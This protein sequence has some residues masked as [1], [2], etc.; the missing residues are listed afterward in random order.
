MSV[1]DSTL[2][3]R[4]KS[5]SRTVYSRV[6]FY[7]ND[8]TM[9][10]SL[11]SSTALISTVVTQPYASNGLTL[12]E[13]C[14]SQ[15]D[16][17][18]YNPEQFG[19]DSQRLLYKGAEFDVYMGFAEGDSIP[20]LNNIVGSAI[21][22]QAIIGGED[23]AEPIFVGRF[24]AEEPSTNDDW[25]TIS[26]RGYDTLSR[27]SETYS[28]TISFPA[29]PLQIY[30]DLRTQYGTDFGF[31]ENGYAV[32]ADRSVLIETED[33]D[34]SME[35]REGS[36]L[37]YLGWIAGA[38]GTNAVI[39]PSVGIIFR[40]PYFLSS[41]TATIVQDFI[42]DRDIQYLRL[43]DLQADDGF[44]V[45]SVTC[46]LE[47][48]SWTSGNGTGLF[49]SNPF[50]SQTLVDN[51]LTKVNG[52]TY[53]PMSCEWRGFP[54]IRGGDTVYLEQKDNT[55]LPSFLMEQ[56]L[57]V[58]SGMKSKVSANKTEEDQYFAES[59]TAKAISKAYNNIK[60]ALEEATSLI[61]SAK[62]GIFRLTD[63]NSDGINDGYVIA[64]DATMSNVTDCIV[65]NYEGIG[66]SSDGGQTYTTA[67]THHGINADVI[68]TG[69]LNAERIRVSGETLSDFVD[70]SPNSQ[71]KV[72]MTFGAKDSSIRLAEVNDKVS[73]IDGADNEL[74]SMTST[75]FDMSNM[76]RFRLGNVMFIIM[77]NGSLSLVGVS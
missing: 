59:P 73:F 40:F 10:F 68:N 60:S 17:K 49:F 52:F 74:M 48:E 43:T 50:G 39:N 61:N 1:Y 51:I 38:I 22:G 6:V 63:S 13:V 34:V 11:L 5:P 25:Y 37:D 57:S 56:V 76:Q 46:S 70:I 42:I 31:Y 4:A 55:L 58:E 18:F 7:P 71:G 33:P 24:Y 53:Y 26:L 65:A 2:E 20:G 75:T 23:D 3:S 54:A 16:L 41:A 29:T 44:E 9:T 66:L 8:P 27:L 45:Q 72:Q 77:P 28:P 35:Y 21:V 47:D 14:I 62:G 19:I 67:I 36:V 30:N 69:H 15:C 12:G 64:S 32:N